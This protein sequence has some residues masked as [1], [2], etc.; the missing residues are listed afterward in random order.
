MAGAIKHVGT[1]NKQKLLGL[2]PTAFENLTYDLLRSGDLT[3]VSWRT[4]GADGGRDIEGFYTERDPSGYTKRARWLI[5]CK[6]YSSTVSWPVVWEKVAYGDSGDADVLLLATSSKFST[7]CIDEIEKWNALNRRPAIRVWP[8]HELLFRL[9]LKI[10]IAQKY[11]L[12]SGLSGSAQ[13]IADLA[14]HVARMT[15]AVMAGIS[16]NV[17]SPRHVYAATSLANLLHVRSIDLAEAGYV[18]ISSGLLGSKLP[19]AYVDVDAGL[20]TTLYDSVGLNCLLACLHVVTKKVSKLSMSNEGIIVDMDN[21]IGQAVAEA[22]L[23]KTVLFW[24]GISVKIIEG[25]GICLIP[26]TLN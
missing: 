6:R 12:V 7:R 25:K 13:S 15:Q 21:E 8:V 3:N 19:P 1:I 22:N 4:P 20:V 14:I 18:R 5:E 11:N 16:A 17:T 9:S 10:E 26:Q 23:I 2:S 24:A